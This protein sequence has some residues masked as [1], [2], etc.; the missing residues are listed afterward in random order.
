M[1]PVLFVEPTNANSPEHLELTA[2][3]DD[4]LTRLPDHLRD[5]VVLCLLQ[6]HTQQQ[7]AEL[8][9][10]DGRAWRRW[11]AGERGINLAAWELYL[12]KTLGLTLRK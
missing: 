5:P 7:A 6:G 10:V 11:E 4:E 8:V 2:I 12:I 3:L 9:H 1:S